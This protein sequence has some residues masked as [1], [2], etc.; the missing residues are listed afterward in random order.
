MYKVMIRDNMSPLA[1]KILEETGQIQVVVDNEKEANTP[2]GL[3]KIIGEFDGL[4]IRSGTKVKGE[5]LENAGKLKVVGRAGIG[6]DNVDVVS[7]TKLG[8]V[9]M[10][11]PGGNTVTTGEHAIALMMA[12]ARQI[13]Q[14]TAS[15]REGKWEKKKFMGVEIAGKTLGIVGLGQI[16]RIVASRAIG[17]Q[18]RVI[19]ADPYVT[20]RAAADL[21]AELVEL[22]ELLSQSDFITLHVPK[23][24]ETRNLIQK[25]A[26]ARMKPGVRIVN[27]SRGE[28]VN[29]D[30]LYEALESGH[31]A[32]AALDVY[33]QE[34]PDTNIPIL[35]HPN[36]ILTPHLGASTGEAQNRVAEMIARQMADYLI[37]GVITN[38]VNFPSVPAEMMGRMGPFLKLGERMGALMGNLVREPQDLEILYAGYVTEFDTRILTHAVL[39]GF[40]DAYT[41]TPVNYVNA[42]SKAKEKGI[43]VRESISQQS[44]DHTN[45]ITLKMPRLQEEANEIW[46]TIF[47]KKYARII[48]IG[49]VYMDVVPEGE[50]L[51]LQG[52]DR[53][54]LI[55]KV[56][57]ILADQGINIGRLYMGR[58]E[59]KAICAINLDSHPGNKVVEQIEALPHIFSVR[60]FLLV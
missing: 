38:A 42:P 24:D 33:P 20:S 60:S 5:A 13:P 53:P 18:M 45:L 15:I 8:I 27:C 30:D 49:R 16:G 50:M 31:V 3:A 43:H 41:D 2:E 10:N 56:G 52:D 32:G 4:A 35:K 21:G 55:G 7:A 40:L 9:V 58:Q 17:L 47:A 37:N 6:V 1:K 23:M 48:R 34:P 29:L 36:V 59:G 25:D 26:L 44:F 12:L 54:G 46:G 14:A 28:V 39:K 19:A 22:D 11:A 57:T 51:I